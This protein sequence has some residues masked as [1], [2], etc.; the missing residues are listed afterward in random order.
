MATG[1]ADC[2]AMRCATQA[3]DSLLNELKYQ[4]KRCLSAPLEPLD[5]EIV[6]AISSV[7]M[8]DF[9]RT[10]FPIKLLERFFPDDDLYKFSKRLNLLKQYWVKNYFRH[11]DWQEVFSDADD[12]IL[13]LIALFLQGRLTAIEYDAA[14]YIYNMQYIVNRFRSNGLHVASFFEGRSYF[15]W[16][17][18]FVDHNPTLYPWLLLW[19]EITDLNACASIENGCTNYSYMQ[20]RLNGPRVVIVV[21]YGR[22]QAIEDHLHQFV[23]PVIIVLFVSEITHPLWHWLL[24]SS[25]WFPGSILSR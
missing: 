11:E 6:L 3:P 1:G 18:N 23:W 22:F 25:K 20:S 14:E 8:L 2:F 17:V 9:S 12:Q 7:Y 5:I 21:W 15:A 10:T 19:A 24:F 13:A 16:I 4:I